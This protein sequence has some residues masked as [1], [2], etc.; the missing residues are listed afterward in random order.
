MCAHCGSTSALAALH[1]YAR[2]PGHVARCPGCGEVVLRMVRS[3]DAVW[4]DLRG[5]VRLRVPVP[6]TG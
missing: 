2:A 4:L 6:A 5:A 3:P 1:V